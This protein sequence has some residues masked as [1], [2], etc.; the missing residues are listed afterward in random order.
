LKALGDPRVDSVLVCNDD[1]MVGF[2]IL[3][4]APFLIEGRKAHPD[5]Y[6]YGSP[7]SLPL[8][9]DWHKFGNGSTAVV[10]PKGVIVVAWVVILAA[11][12]RLAFGLLALSQ[13]TRELSLLKAPHVPRIDPL[14]CISKVDASVGFQIGLTTSVLREMGTEH[15]K[16]YS[17]PP[18]SCFFCDPI[19][20]ISGMV[21]QRLSFQCVV[22]VT[23]KAIFRASLCI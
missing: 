22:T 4:P 20:T 16:C 2:R 21:R 17:P 14:L 8:S 9:L 1:T 13:V 10:V 6:A 3:S 7:K 15:P 12:L 5:C 23:W 18:Q 19:D 11:S